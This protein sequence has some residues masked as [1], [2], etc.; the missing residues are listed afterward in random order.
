MSE[1]PFSFQPEK[2][3]ALLCKNSRTSYG[4]TLALGLPLPR[5]MSQT[6]Q[7]VQQQLEAAWPKQ[8]YWYRPEQF[9]AT[10]VAPLRG[11]YR[12]EPPIQ[13]SELPADL[14]RFVADLGCCLELLRPFPLSIT[15]VRAV[16]NGIISLKIDGGF[17]ARQALATCLSAYPTLDAPKHLSNLHMTIGYLTTPDFGTVPSNFSQR[18][19][20]MEAEPLGSIVVNHIWLVHYANRT[21]E[22][23]IA[24]HPFYLGKENSI[25]ANQLLFQLQI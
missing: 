22:Q 7:Q 9:H 19:A 23:V 14:D 17:H 15:G 5:S 25:T 1:R 8:F 4:L 11:R 10:L 18:L 3:A 16:P 20:A 21:L 12:R 2:I 6:I 24:K 13:R